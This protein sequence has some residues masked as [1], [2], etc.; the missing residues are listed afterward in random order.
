MTK[1][2]VYLRV[3]GNAR[4]HG[5]ASPAIEAIRIC[6]KANRLKLVRVFRQEGIGGTKEL[7]NRPALEL[8]T[9]LHSNG[10]KLLLI[11]KRDRLARDLMV[12]ETIKPRRSERWHALT[13][14]KILTGKGRKES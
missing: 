2:F 12:Q 3:S 4:V 13:I 10:V 1:E 6:V 8:M 7:E 9:A 5:M 11:E 14:N